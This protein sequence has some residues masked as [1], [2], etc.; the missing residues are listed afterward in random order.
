MKKYIFTCSL[1]FMLISCRAISGNYAD[2]A[3]YAKNTSEKNISFEAGI[4]KNSMSMGRYEV[5]NNFQVKPNDSILIIRTSFK[6]DYENPQHMFPTFNVFP[7]E[8][9]EL[10]DAKNPQNWK[11]YTKENLVIY[12]FT[13]NK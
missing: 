6:K 13:L 12:T 7:P 10:N 5:K 3:F 11:K 8:N 1:V 2:T 9:V 4:F